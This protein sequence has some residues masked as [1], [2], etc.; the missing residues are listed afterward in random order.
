MVAASARWPASVWPSALAV[1][2][3]GSAL[4]LGRAG[5]TTGVDIALSG[6]SIG[7]KAASAV[8]TTTA[9]DGTTVP[10]GPATGLCA[11]L[12]S[13]PDDTLPTCTTTS[14]VEPP[15]AI[16][17]PTTPTGPSTH[18]EDHHPAVH[19]G[20]H[21]GERDLAAE[22][23]RLRLVVAGRLADDLPAASHLRG[24][25]DRRL[26]RRR[27]G[28]PPSRDLSQRRSRPP[29]TT[30]YEVIG[31]H[32]VRV[33]IDSGKSKVPPQ[34]LE[35]EDCSSLAADGTSSNLVTVGNCVQVIG[36]D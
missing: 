24:L 15:T 30:T 9:L 36:H 6:G 18:A 1:V 2:I 29:V 3:G 28:H 14:T 34:T 4:A 33:T 13:S 26:Q 7:G 16:G 22:G 21:L 8:S 23:R 5:S 25:P 31:V 12:E 19:R 20:H 11:G 27:P 10:S 35:V 32:K 17:T